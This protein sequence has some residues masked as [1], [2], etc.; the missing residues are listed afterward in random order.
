M[1]LFFTSKMKKLKESSIEALI[2]SCSEGLVNRKSSY[3][4]A[5][6][7]PFTMKGSSK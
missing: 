3:L 7:L 1:F 5:L 6:I 2:L 4:Q